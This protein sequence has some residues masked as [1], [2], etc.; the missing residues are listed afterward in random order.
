MMVPAPGLFSTI[1][2]RPRRFVRPSAISRAAVSVP[3]PA[4]IAT[5]MR[6]GRLG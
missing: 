6:T 3:L 1:T 2:C 4:G 5:M